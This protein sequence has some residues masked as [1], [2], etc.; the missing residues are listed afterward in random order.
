MTQMKRRMIKDVYPQMYNDY[1]NGMSVTE[2]SKKYFFKENSIR[3]YFN[4]Q[5]IIFST[6]IKFSQKELSNIIKD[7]QNGARPFE[8]AK[9]YNR[10]SATI[11][12]KLKEIGLYKNTNYHFTDEDIE[13]LKVHYPLGNWDLIDKKFKDTSRQSIHTK[14]HKLGISADKYFDDKMWTKYELEILKD[15][16]SYGNIDMILKIL[17]NR[18]YKSIVTKAKRIGLFTRSF[19]TNK[20]DSIMK[21]FYHS[22]TVDEIME[23]LPNRTRNSII[24]HARQ[25]NLVSVCKYAKEE[26]Q[27]IIDNWC[28]MSD[29]ELAIVLSKPFRSVKSKRQSL[30][31]FRIKEGSSYNNL[32]EY[33][34]KNN[35]E[36]KEKSMINC[37]YK[38]V[39]TGNRFD[40]IHH[41]YSLNLILNETLEELNIDIKPT[42]DDY[43][44]EELDDILNIFRIKQSEYPLGVCVC[45][46]VHMLF[47]NKYGYG[48]NTEEQWKE[49][50]NDFKSGKY[51]E[52]VA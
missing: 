13:F 36:W 48:N 47:H 50:F 44:G 35:L 12:G 42:M 15:N 32:S 3:L 10:N 52:N 41:I 33:V 6:A 31:L 19:W 7:Y 16:Y 45:K 21:Q 27:Y 38:C 4:K 34:R 26:T 8:L 22:K 23:L 51:N 37:K 24:E 30:G 17:P 5:G 9:K 46:E 49:F 25:L 28:E 29:E 2:M 20:E 40:E 11:I 1:K 39:L 43:T 14:M 18:S